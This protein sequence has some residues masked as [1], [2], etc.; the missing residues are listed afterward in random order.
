[1]M[2]IAIEGKTLE[3]CEGDITELDTDAIVNAANS[4]LILGGGVAGAI[5][6][7]G[8]PAIQEECNRIGGTPV[9]TAAITTGGRL[10]ARHVIHAVGPRMGEGDEDRKLESATRSSLNVAE[11][12]GLRSIAFPAISTGI[13]GYPID[14]CARIM[15]SVALERL[16]SATPLNRIAFCLYGNDAYQV[17]ETT[18]RSLLADPSSAR[19]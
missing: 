8:G 9:G 11:A 16:R 3:L 17:F 7:K 5:A 18:L 4:R 10:R 14:R 19:E 2:K 6:R 12:N 13:F 1:M 15:L